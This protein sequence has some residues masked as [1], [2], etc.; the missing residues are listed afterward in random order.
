MHPSPQC[1]CVA[2]LSALL[3]IGLGRERAQAQGIQVT[4]VVVEFEA[5]QMATTITVTN[6]GANTVAIQVRPFAWQQAG[7]SDT[8][9][10][11]NDLAVSP[12]IADVGAGVAQTF[13]IV[14]RKAVGSVEAAYRLLLDQIPSSQAGPGVQ[15]ALRLSLPV[16]VEPGG[17]VA[18]SVE[19]RIASDGRTASLVATNKGTSRTR[20][21]TPELVGPGMRRLA[22]VA[23]GNPYILPGTER[24]WRISGGAGLQQGMSARLTGQ[25][26][27]G[28][29]DVPVPVTAR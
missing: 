22:V 4:P 25:S 15:F 14:S 21:L 27:G 6:T 8:L 16:F 26:D 18:P 29:V 12:P 17:R 9:T 23:N 24:V 10:P 7:D 20:L 11:T 1:I 5:G 2:L 19:W 28:R 3:L 13:R